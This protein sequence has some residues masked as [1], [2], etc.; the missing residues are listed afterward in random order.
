MN[1]NDARQAYFPIE[2][3]LDPGK[4]NQYLFQ[5]QADAATKV[6]IPPGG[7]EV[8]FVLLSGK[9]VGRYDFVL[10]TYFEI[11]GHKGEVQTDGKF[12]LIQL[13]EN[14]QLWAAPQTSTEGISL[15]LT[16]LSKLLEPRKQTAAIDIAQDKY[17]V[18]IGAFSRKRNALACYSRLKSK[19]YA[20][21]LY[22]ATI[23][24][25]RLFQVRIGR[26]ISKAQALSF[27]KQ[28]DKKDVPNF[29][30][31]ETDKQV[32]SALQIADYRP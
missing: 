9:E 30:V 13:D 14:K 1:T 26:F 15:P 20:T 10:N 2:L 17:S 11:N 25:R 29:Y 12:R 18:Q 4:K 5:T 7:S 19:G 23:K 3:S 21:F 28:L 27:A 32:N 22:S 8:F 24:N 6:S 31:V 16:M